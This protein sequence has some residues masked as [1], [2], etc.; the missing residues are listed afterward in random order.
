M[1]AP[2]G[3]MSAVPERRHLCVAS[4]RRQLDANHDDDYSSDY[5]DNYSSDYD[6]DYDYDDSSDYDANYDAATPVTTTP[7]RRRLWR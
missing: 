1:D 2:V 3:Y 5:D 6:A 7:I 4:S